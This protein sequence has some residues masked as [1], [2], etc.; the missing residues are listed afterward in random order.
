LK[1]ASIEQYYATQWLHV[2]AATFLAKPMFHFSRRLLNETTALQEA[3]M[4]HPENQKAVREILET[5]GTG[6]AATI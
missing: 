4:P 3:A 2:N 6:L 1:T 5:L